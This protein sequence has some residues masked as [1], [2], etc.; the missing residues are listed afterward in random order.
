MLPKDGLVKFRTIANKKSDVGKYCKSAAMEILHP[1][2]MLS[3]F[4]VIRVSPRSMLW[5]GTETIRPTSTT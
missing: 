5:P 3:W 1:K 4:F 2:T